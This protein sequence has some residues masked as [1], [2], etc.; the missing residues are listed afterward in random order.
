MPE[1]L[2]TA[3]DVAQ[4]LAISPVHFRR[5]RA[6]MIAKGLGVVRIPSAQDGKRALVRYTASS[7]ERLMD[8]AEETEALLC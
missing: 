5:L 6:D 4:R 3:T 1:Q 7:L 2:L 8:R